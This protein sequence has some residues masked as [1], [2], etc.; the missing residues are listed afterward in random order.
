MYRASANFGC[1]KIHVETV[2]EFYVKKL[3]R[4]FIHWRPLTLDAFQNIAFFGGKD[5]LI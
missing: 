3:S 4:L 5:L 2:E 1:F